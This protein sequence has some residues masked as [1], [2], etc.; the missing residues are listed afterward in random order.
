[1]I[2]CGHVHVSSEQSVRCPS[3]VLQQATGDVD[4]EPAILGLERERRPTRG[5]PIGGRAPRMSAVWPAAGLSPSRLGVIDRAHSCVP[6]LDISSRGEQ[7]SSS[8]VPRP[9]PTSPGAERRL[10]CPA[11]ARR[12]AGHDTTDPDAAAGGRMIIVEV[13]APGS[14]PRGPPS[15]GAG[16]RI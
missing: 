3:G 5:P 8:S 7:R 14:A 12:Q 4:T 2:S 16:I 13:F 15:S 10:T 1:V 9:S 11:L 6:T